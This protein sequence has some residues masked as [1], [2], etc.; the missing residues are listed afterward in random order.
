MNFDPWSWPMTLNKNGPSWTTMPNIYVRGH[1]VRKFLNEHT[2]THT[3]TH[4]RRIALSGPLKWSVK[5]FDTITTKDTIRNNN[6]KVSVELLRCAK[7]DFSSFAIVVDILFWHVATRCSRRRQ[8]SPPVPQPGKMDKTY[9]SS[10][11]L[12]HL[13]HYVKTLR[14]PQ[15]RK[16]ITVVSEKPINGHG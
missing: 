13:F 10:L 16:Y 5:I 2:H 12:A 7:S 3:H 11:I 1:F 8:T 9:A 6:F 4:S 14:H 15:K